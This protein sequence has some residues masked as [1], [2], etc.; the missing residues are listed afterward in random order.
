M[1]NYYDCVYYHLY[2]QN[3]VTAIATSMSNA[4]FVPDGIHIS[5]YY[6]TNANVF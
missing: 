6:V 4:L 1:T 5:L 2:M 3:Y